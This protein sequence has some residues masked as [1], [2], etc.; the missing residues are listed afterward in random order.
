M[1][2][3]VSCA[4]GGTQYPV[5]RQKVPEARV[6]C[7]TSV[8]CQDGRYQVDG[9]YLSIKVADAYISRVNKVTNLSFF[10]WD[11]LGFTIENPTSWQLP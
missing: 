2:E 8:Q 4:H 9:R 5:V 10:A 7:V 1:V 6:Q 11:F 3:M